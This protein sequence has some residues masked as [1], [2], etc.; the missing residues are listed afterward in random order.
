MRK[1]DKK[2]ALSLATVRALNV[3]TGGGDLSGWYT[4]TS[5]CRSSCYFGDCRSGVCPQ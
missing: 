5:A 1:P 4:Q 2:L 3:A